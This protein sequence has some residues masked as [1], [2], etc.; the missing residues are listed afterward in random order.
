MFYE[1]LILIWYYLKIGSNWRVGQIFN[2]I[3]VVWCKSARGLLKVY[4]GSAI[5]VP[6][7]LKW[8]E[9]PSF[10]TACKPALCTFQLQMKRH[11]SFFSSDL[12]VCFWNRVLFFMSVLGLHMVSLGL[13]LVSP[14]STIADPKQ[15]LRLHKS[16][17]GFGWGLHSVRLG[18]K[19]H[20]CSNL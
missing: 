7:A 18:I 2:H 14:R 15:T 3:N 12:M 16:D 10:F 8:K 13:F 20:V 6:F 17:P 19:L 1:D 9:N 5:G 11:W 4:P